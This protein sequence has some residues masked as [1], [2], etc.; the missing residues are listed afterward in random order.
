VIK[1]TIH[2]DIQHGLLDITGLVE[3][4]VEQANVNSGICC[5]YCPH[6][7]AAI[8]VYSGVDPLGL[9]DI[10]DTLKILVPTRADFHH[11]CDPPSDAAGHIKSSLIGPS[12]T[13]IIED[14]KLVLGSSQNIYFFEFDGPRDRQFYIQITGV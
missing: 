13:F 7:T 6:T 10:N 4:D 12:M 1:H 9:L 11:Q 2:T 14:G 8:T 5:V 3:K